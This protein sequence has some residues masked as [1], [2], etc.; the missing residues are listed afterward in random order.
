[1]KPSTSDFLH[2]VLTLLAHERP[3]FHSE[4]DFQHSLALQVKEAYPLSTVRLEWPFR[5]NVDSKRAYLDM[6]VHAP[7]GDSIAVEL[8]YRT[9]PLT[10]Q[11]FGE[12]YE[13]ADQGSQDTGR[14]DFIKDIRRLEALVITGA[15]THGIAIMLTND[16]RYWTP[17]KSDSTHD[18]AF[19]LHGGRTIEGKLAW[20]ASASTGT[21]Q[22]RDLI[23]RLQGK[24]E[25]NWENY[26][27]PSSVGFG[28]FRY[29]AVEAKST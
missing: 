10:L 9:C 6:L 3:L 27:T 5:E 25:L 12:E 24:Y 13:L 11:I 8:K 20:S 4:A 1:M 22:E 14:H 15:S 23:L 28:T 19:R 26:S 29:L 7:N 21:T 18:A 17:S 16:P 2:Q